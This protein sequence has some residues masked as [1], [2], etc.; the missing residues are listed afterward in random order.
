MYACGT[1][2]T[3]KS[4]ELKLATFERKI[5]RRI[6]GPKTNNEG[7]YKIRT[8]QEIQDL[9]GE[10]NIN[11][12]LKSSRLSWAGHVWRSE[13]P[14]GQV[15][16]W[17]PN[18]KRPRGRPRQRWKDRVVKNLRELGIEDGEELARDRDRWRQVVVAAMGLNGL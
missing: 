15:T 11:G 8:N 3:T 14:I 17:K 1:W 4:D 10:P 2:A 7:E 13:G 5:L 12:I 18:T 6:Y 16:K 9:Y